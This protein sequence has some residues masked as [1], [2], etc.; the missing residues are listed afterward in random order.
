MNLM[1]LLLLAVCF[2][3]WRV[4]KDGEKQREI[5]E[6]IAAGRPR[7]KARP[8]KIVVRKAPRKGARP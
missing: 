3:C 1:L 6:R 7:P 2:F 4:R 8:K 5:L